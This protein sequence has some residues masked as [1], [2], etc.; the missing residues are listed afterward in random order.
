MSIK[1]FIKQIFMNF[2]IITTFVTLATA[3]VGPFFM[4]DATFGFGAFYSPLF[5]SAIGTLPS[6]IFFSR[7]ELNFKQTVIRRILHL[8]VLEAVL[9]GFALLFNNFTEIY[10]ALMFMLMVFIIYLAVSIINLL[11]GGKD[12]KQIN[13]GLKS[14]QNRE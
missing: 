5:A 4:P 10:G 12:A 1:S 13:D 3:I 2:F 14:L 8:A 11:L 9:T 6:F 7:K